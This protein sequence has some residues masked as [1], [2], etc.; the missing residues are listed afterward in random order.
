MEF[1]IGEVR[2]KLVPSGVR[3]GF[4]VGGHK[5]DLSVAVPTDENPTFEVSALIDG[6][7]IDLTVGT[8]VESVAP[9]A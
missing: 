5:I 6:R 4:D 8:E 1:K 3:I 7:Q 2:F 9:K